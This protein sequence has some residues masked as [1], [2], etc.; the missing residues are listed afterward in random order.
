MRKVLKNL[1]FSTPRV[2]KNSTYVPNNKTMSMTLK[3]SSQDVHTKQTNQKSF[4]TK[5]QHCCDPQCSSKYF[6]LDFYHFPFKVS[7]FRMSHDCWSF[8]IF[9]SQGKPQKSKSIVLVKF[10][11][12][13]RSRL[14]AVVVDAKIKNTLRTCRI[15][16]SMDLCRVVRVILLKSWNKM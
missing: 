6:V 9:H 15:V 1:S 5:Q 11:F 16:S 3:I 2:T 12:Q 4:Q 7:I 10:I 14:W 13:S 8:R